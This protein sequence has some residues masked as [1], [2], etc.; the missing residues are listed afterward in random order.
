MEVSRRFFLYGTAALP[1][2]AA[3]GR[4]QVPHGGVYT[5]EAFGATGDGRT[6]D[7]DA[8]AAMTTAV[9]EAGGGTILLK[10]TTYQVGRQL[11]G[12]AAR[13]G[14]SFEPAPIM[15]FVGLDLALTIRRQW[16]PSARRGRPTLRY[17]C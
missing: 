16:R 1:L 5:P 10:R 14:Y 17:I 12:H 3:V 8:F 13:T 7:T 15:D 9:S 11:R 4:T 6:N 2:A